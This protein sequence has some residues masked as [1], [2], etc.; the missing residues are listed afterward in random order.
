MGKA[1]MAI[2]ALAICLMVAAHLRSRA[3]A[4]GSPEDPAG[5]IEGR[6]P[7]VAPPPPPGRTGKTVCGYCN[8][9]RRIDAADRQRR[10][11]PFTSAPEGPCPYCKDQP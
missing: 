4:G 7:G 8:G 11:P 5:A 3:A 10:T 6:P 2:A 1:L 9:D